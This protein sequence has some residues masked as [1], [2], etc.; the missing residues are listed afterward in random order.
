MIPILYPAN[1]TQFQTNGLGALKDVKMCEVHEVLNGEYE[2]TME[3][4]V[5]GQRFEDIKKTRLV[6]A[7]PSPQEDPQPFEIYKIDKAL[8]G[9]VTIYAQ[10]ISYRLSLI[11]VAPFTASSPLE[12][13]QKITQKAF[14][15]VPFTIT[16]DTTRTG[17]FSLEQP[18]SA[19]AVIGDLLTKYGLEVRWSGF[20]VYLATIRGADNGVKI[21]YGKN[22]TELSHESDIQETATGIVPYWTGMGGTGTGTDTLVGDLYI[23]PDKDQRYPYSRVITY[24]FSNWFPEGHVPTK[25]E[26]N[27]AAVQYMANYQNGLPDETT[28]LSFIPLW[29]TEEFKDRASVEMVSLGDTIRVTS[30]NIGADITARI[31]EVTWDVLKE[32]YEDLITGKARSGLSEQFTK[33]E[34]KI[35]NDTALKTAMQIAIDKATDMITGNNGG[36]I[37]FQYD[38]DGKPYEML[39]M[40]TDDIATAQNVWRFNQAGLGHSSNGYN[41]PYSLAMLMDGSINASMITTG[42]LNANLITTGALNADLITTGTLNADLIRSGVI[43][44]QNDRLFFNLNN[45]SLKTVDIWRYTTP[46]YL[47]ISNQVRWRGE[48]SFDSGGD[49]YV[50]TSH[51]DSPSTYRSRSGT[52]TLANFH[53]EHLH[54][55]DS[56]GNE[57][58]YGVFDM[59]FHD[60]FKIGAFFNG[61]SYEKMNVFSLDPDTH[62]T[63]RFH[64]GDVRAGLDFEASDVRVYDG[65]YLYSA[66]SGTIIVSTENGDTVWLKVINGILCNE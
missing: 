14:L 29:L 49:K 15:T 16:V 55:Y 51:P 8:N 50:I 56:S 5:T 7:K 54:V 17:E 28:N 42:D 12:A 25:S 65:N 46:T 53:A 39:V 2:L 24:D 48:R 9:N 35:E 11:P 52:S 59:E 20:N 37:K 62:G 19:R 33:V 10:H 61:N 38:A 18:K 3:Y 45:G 4:P 43:R 57:Y 36:Y 58:L 32:R 30:E 66:Y 6:L 47:P 31:V 27:Q 13:V 34:E 64:L 21:S 1:E 22:L 60:A 40:D 23:D 41:G 26:L 63:Y 44:D